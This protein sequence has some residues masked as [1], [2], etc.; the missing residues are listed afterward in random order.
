ML[1]KSME[2]LISSEGIRLKAVSNLLSFESNLDRR[3][4]C[5]N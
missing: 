5:V 2:L 3:L 1:A 4:V